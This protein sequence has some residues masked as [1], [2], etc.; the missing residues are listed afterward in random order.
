MFKSFFDKQP[1]CPHTN[2]TP[3]MKGGYCTDCGKY[4]E[5]QWFITRCNCC[6]IKHQTIFTKGKIKPETRYCKNCGSNSYSVERLDKINIVDINYAII[7]KQIINNERR[8]FIQ[9][10]VE[11]EFTPI[12]LIEQK[13]C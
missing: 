6:G 13:C 4:V 10:W 8:S 3:D 11:R 7:I 2:I 12:K 9:T 5:N 1:D